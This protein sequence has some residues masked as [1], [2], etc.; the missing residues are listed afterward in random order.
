MRF[1]GGGGGLARRDLGVRGLAET[2]DDSKGGGGMAE[3]GVARC[4]RGLRL[5]VRGEPLWWCILTVLAF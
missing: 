1:G 5:G 3:E 2:R 4:G